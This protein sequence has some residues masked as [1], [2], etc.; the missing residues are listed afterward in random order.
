MKTPNTLYSRLVLITSVTLVVGYFVAYAWTTIDPVNNGDTLTST[1]IN[2]MIGNLT[3]L[4][5]RVSNFTFSSGKVGIGTATPQATLDVNG[6]ISGQGPAGEAVISSS[7]SAPTGGNTIIT[8]FTTT[9][10][11]TVGG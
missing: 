4:D 2:N 10:S 5:T 9:T 3:D 11:V 8:G 1:L 7:F 6:S